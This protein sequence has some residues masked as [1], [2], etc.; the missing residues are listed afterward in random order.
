MLGTIQLKAAFSTMLWSLIGTA[1]RGD[2]DPD[3]KALICGIPQTTVG[4]SAK[5]I[6]SI[7]QP[8]VASVWK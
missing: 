6:S 1:T 4:A 5:R 8:F 7:C 2:K 3:T